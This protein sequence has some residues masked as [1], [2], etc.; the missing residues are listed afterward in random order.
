MI[1]TEYILNTLIMDGSGLINFC[2]FVGYRSAHFIRILKIKLI[3]SFINISVDF[4]YLLS[5]ISCFTLYNSR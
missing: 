3:Y 5:D 1:I 2:Q 4:N